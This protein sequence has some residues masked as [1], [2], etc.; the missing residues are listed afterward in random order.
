M[1]CSNCGSPL[2][3]GQNVCSRCGMI[4]GQVNNQMMQNNQ[5]SQNQVNLNLVNNQNSKKNKTTTILLSV[6]IILLL[7]FLVLLCALL[8]NKDEEEKLKKNPES[9]T[10]TIMI[11][12]SPTNLESDVWALTSDLD[13]LS[14]E[15]VDLENI[16]VL[17]YTGGTKKWHNFIK[18]DENAIYILK[19]DGFE[20]LES[21][22]QKNMSSSSTLLEFLNYSYEN[23]KTDLYDLI[24]Y[25]HGGALT[26]A[27]ADDFNK[28][29]LITLAEFDGALQESP[30]GTEQKLEMVLFRTCIMSTLE[31][32]AI[33]DSYADY[34][35]A[36]EEIILA[37]GKKMYPSCL[38][39]I[40]DLEKTDNAKSFA[41]AF[42]DSYE[43]FLKES[44]YYNEQ[45]VAYSMIDLS[46]IEDIYEELDMFSEGIDL[47]KDY[48]NISKI[49]SN[50]YQYANTGADASGEYDIVDL[51]NMVKELDDY[52]SYDGNKIL[53]LLDE[54]IIYNNT[55]KKGNYGLAIFF[56]YNSK[57]YLKKNLSIY[58]NMD[59]GKK[60]YELIDEFNTLKI[61]K[62]SNS[63]T[64]GMVASAST[65]IVNSDEFKLDLTAEQ[66]EDF[67]RANYMVFKK[68][69]D[70]YMPV[71]ISNNATLSGNTLQSNITNRIVR[72]KNIYDDNGKEI[73]DAYLQIVD[74]SED[75]ESK[76]TT[77]GVITNI[78]NETF[79]IDM[80]AVTYTIVDDNGKPSVSLIKK[81]TTEDAPN[82][83]ILLKDDFTHY[84]FMTFQYKFFDD[85]GN[86]TTDWSSNPTKY[87]YESK[88]NELD[89]EFTSLSGTGEY[90]CIFR[91]FDVYGNSSYTKP[92]KLN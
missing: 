84:E 1:N 91:I 49:R 63:L 5:V 88:I 27:I 20:K 12:A 57:T 61:S 16:N 28:S 4:N 60:Y 23:Y 55:N 2:N 32:A 76:Y 75:G 15:E 45:L 85:N 67:A 66:V 40:N 70:Y 29:D 44:G 42:I 18:N 31:V 22:E 80:E 81:V 74:Q 56:P 9:G 52:S 46:K 53:N 54:T 51:Y 26:G 50:L 41:K 59:I 90:Y 11:Y 13:T 89:L 35:V 58:K 10:R 24:L 25:D 86:Y 34:M 3:P 78:N 33:F 30:F 77:N 69:D 87:G 72:I 71:F 6:I 47:E 68:I 21:Y 37:G 79:D 38:D 64:T 7:L 83:G 65:I 73:T 19:E 82:G 62:K 8:F 92:V 17:L 48:N 39:F 43:Y 36:S 14:G